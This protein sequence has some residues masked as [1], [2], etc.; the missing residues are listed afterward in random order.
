MLIV[1]TYKYDYNWDFFDI[2]SEE[3]YYF[4]GFVGADGYIGKD[5]IEIG[6][7]I[8]D[9]SLLNKFRK[10]ICP[11]KPLY[12]RKDTNAAVLKISCKQRINEMKT[13][14]G[15]KT[16][17]KGNEMIFP[18]IS[19]NYIKDFIRGY[20][21]GDG[22]IDKTKAYW[23][24]KVYIGKRLRIL[25]NYNFLETLNQKTKLFVNHNTNLISKKGKENI[26]Y[27]TY[28]FSTADNIL[29]WLYED[30][31]ICLER[32]YKKAIYPIYKW[33]DEDIV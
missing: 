17:K 4:L 30:C 12:I 29:K 19:M 20:I 9:I 2:D 16:S 7:S 1:G 33:Q 32:K 15:M 18:D 24:T 14:F 25:G 28:N 13:F 11:N 31:K 27:V 22:C 3:L 26:Y 10:M 21:D 6:L 8:K 5:S 23:K